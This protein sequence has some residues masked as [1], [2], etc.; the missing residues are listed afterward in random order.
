M[1]ETDYL[2]DL[3]GLGYAHLQETFDDSLTWGSVRSP[4][5]APSVF[6]PGIIWSAN[7]SNSGVSTSTGPARTGWAFFSSP[8]GDY[9]SG[10][11]CDVPGGCGDGF[12]GTSD[13]TL[14]GVGGWISGTVGADIDFILDGDDLNPITFDGA[15][16]FTGSSG[17]LFFGVIDTDGF[18]HFEVRELE[19][20]IGD[21]KLIW[22]DDVI[23]GVP[24]PSTRMLSSVAM[25]CL[26]LLR[27]RH[28]TLVLPRFRGQLE[29]VV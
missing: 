25:I 18:T 19:G 7:N 17:H 28:T 26:A 14:F 5:T 3:S 9:A 8:H 13:E 27:R 15:P 11:G 29:A 22:I 21:Q 4:A 2:N 23:I 20:T 24:E 1:N 12:I 6:S 16:A 10:T